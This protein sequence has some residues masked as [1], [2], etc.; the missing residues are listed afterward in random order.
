VKK[1]DKEGTPGVKAENNKPAD[2]KRL[3]K[4]LN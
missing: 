4:Q 1:D 2:K 3:K